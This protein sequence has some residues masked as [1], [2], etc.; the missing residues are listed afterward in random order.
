M[1]TY[2]NLSLY[3]YRIITV[4]PQTRT[5]LCSVTVPFYTQ[6]MKVCCRCEGVLPELE[7]ISIMG[8]LQ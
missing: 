3:D 7:Q 5:K 1:F 6:D 4:L 2:P 8:Q